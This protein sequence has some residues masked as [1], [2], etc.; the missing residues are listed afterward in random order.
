MAAG[1]PC[2]GLCGVEIVDPDGGAL[3]GE[4]GDRGDLI[5]WVERGRGHGDHW[6]RR[7]PEEGSQQAVGVV[8]P[9]RGPSD[10]EDEPE[11]ADPF[12]VRRAQADGFFPGKQVVF[13]K[14]LGACHGAVGIED[15]VDVEQ[16]G[17]TRHLSSM[18]AEARTLARSPAAANAVY[19]FV[20]PAAYGRLSVST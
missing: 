15:S 6:E 20:C 13:G 16:Q 7:D 1:T 8:V 12:S 9:G 19:P 17:G 10:V 2:P 11:L 18:A 4:P 3:P 5:A 14:P